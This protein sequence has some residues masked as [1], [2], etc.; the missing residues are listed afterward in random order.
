MFT[1]K[2]IQKKLRQC[3]F[4]NQVHKRLLKTSAKHNVMN[5]RGLLQEPPKVSP[6]ETE[7]SADNG[8]G[9]QKL[10]ALWYVLRQAGF[11]IYKHG[12]VSWLHI[13]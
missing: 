2:I 7:I 8:M 5:F 11:L 4:Y 13:W 6:Q 3:Y 12:G 1:N 10:C 9:N